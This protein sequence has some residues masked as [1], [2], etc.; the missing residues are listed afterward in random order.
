MTKK[1]IDKL[2]AEP[3]ARRYFG[4]VVYGKFVCG[5]SYL[6]RRL[7]LAANSFNCLLNGDTTP[8]SNA[9]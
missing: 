2:G 4:G 8:S 5:L 6:M 1:D 3:L 7:L 9:S